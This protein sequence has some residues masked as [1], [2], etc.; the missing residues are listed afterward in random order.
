[1]EVSGDDNI[2]LF[3]MESTVRRHH[4]YKTIWSRAVGK[5]LQ[6]HSKV[7]NIHDLYEVSLIKLGTGVV[8]HI[9]R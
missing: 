1:M 6:C 9:P 3:L 2:A 5:E 4:V 7:D 8:G